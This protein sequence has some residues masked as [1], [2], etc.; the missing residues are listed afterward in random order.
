MAQP[1]VA[2]ELAVR[3]PSTP[4]TTERSSSSPALRALDERLQ[5]DDTPRG[6][7]MLVK[8]RGVVIKQDGDAREREQKLALEE[9]KELDK[10]RANGHRRRLATI[11]AIVP[12]AH[13]VVAMA[14]G[15]YLMSAG[16]HREGLFMLAGAL[17]MTA[18]WKM[19]RLLI[20]KR[21]RGAS[22]VDG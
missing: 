22:N 8:L 4:Q 20:E 21:E 17:S 13:F 19:V 16:F 3:Q 2:T 11:K 7:E 10:L 12:A 9:R 6:L 15:L 18:A 5:R 14:T 1:E